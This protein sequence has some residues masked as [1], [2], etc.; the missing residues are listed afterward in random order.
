MSP[1]ILG[2]VGLGAVATFLFAFTLIPQKSPLTK[3][4]QELESRGRQ[5]DTRSVRNFEKIFSEERRGR[6]KRK[7]MEAG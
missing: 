2:I 3:T 7:L 6:L 5:R 4:L 1:M